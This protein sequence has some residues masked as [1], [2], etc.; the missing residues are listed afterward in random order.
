LASI[1]DSPIAAAITWVSM[2]AAFKRIVTVKG[3]KPSAVRN[4]MRRTSVEMMMDAS[5]GAC[6]CAGV[7][8]IGGSGWACC[9]TADA[10]YPQ[11]KSGDQQGDVGAETIL[12]GVENDRPLRRIAVHACGDLSER[13]AFLD[14]VIVPAG[15]RLRCEAVAS[16]R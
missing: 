6:V 14:C 8:A 1:F 4:S 13:F 15:L 9:R 7:V 2:A 11:R 12:V 16:H 3:A 5:L 10:G